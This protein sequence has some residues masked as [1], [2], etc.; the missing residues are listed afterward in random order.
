MP[1][2][3][4]IA[5]RLRF[6]TPTPAQTDALASTQAVFRACC[7]VQC[8]ITFNPNRTVIF[9]RYLRRGHCRKMVAHV[10]PSF[11]KC[12]LTSAQSLAE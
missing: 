5:K 6:R 2:M 7:I 9:N 8:K 3:A 10:A 11:A 12:K 1:P 4:A